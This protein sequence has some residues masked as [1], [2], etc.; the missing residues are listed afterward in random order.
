MVFPKLL[1]NWLCKNIVVFSK[2][3]PPNLEPSGDSGAETVVW[4]PDAPCGEGTGGK[5]LLVAFCSTKVMG[6]PKKPWT[7]EVGDGK[8]WKVTIFWESLSDVPVFQLITACLP[9][10]F[11]SCGST[12]LFIW[13]W[14][15]LPK[16]YI[17]NL[18]SWGFPWFSLRRKAY[19][20]AAP[21]AGS[22]PMTAGGI[23]RSKN[24]CRWRW[25]YTFG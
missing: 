14:N 7:Y 24:M 10:V 15:L 4:D 21:N 18:E 12:C 1:N 19:I 9:G 23:P 11:G 6:S 2:I 20:H 17:W 5:R 13:I 16:I 22:A 3:I 25:S 8:F